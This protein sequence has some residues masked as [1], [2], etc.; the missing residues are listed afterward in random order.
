[1][2]DY[3]LYTYFIFDSLKILLYNKNHLWD[4][5]YYVYVIVLLTYNLLHISLD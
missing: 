5:E 2:F 3:I 4:P 1:M